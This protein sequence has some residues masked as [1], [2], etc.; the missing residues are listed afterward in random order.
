MQQ[1]RYVAATGATAL[2]TLHGT[3]TDLPGVDTA[4][5]RRTAGAKQVAQ[6]GSL[7]ARKGALIV[8]GDTRRG[9]ADAL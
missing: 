9:I 4:Q 5:L 7:V 1:P 2:G 6:K 8:T 3:V